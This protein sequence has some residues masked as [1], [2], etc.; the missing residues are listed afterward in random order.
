MLL[1]LERRFLPD[2]KKEGRENAL[3]HQSGQWIKSVSKKS[4]EK[5]TH[6]VDI[7][8]FDLI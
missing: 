6:T 3:K 7:A 2:G 5:S 8:C 1:G 4:A